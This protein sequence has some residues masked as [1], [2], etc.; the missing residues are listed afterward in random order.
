M[1]TLHNS[2]LANNSKLALDTLA[3]FR[4]V[5]KSANR[6]FHKI[7]QKAGIGGASLW[8]LAEIAESRNLTVSGLAKAMAVHQSTASNLMEKLETSG[9]VLRTRSTEDRRVVYLEV[10]QKGQSTLDRAP[11]PY[12]GILPDALMRLDPAS[13]EQLN[14]NINKLVLSLEHKQDN[15]GYEPLGCD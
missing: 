11:P 13:L 15:A 14:Q 3:L 2:K 6:H 9:Y 7:E 10:T 5:F 4:V 1:S 12:R 8:A